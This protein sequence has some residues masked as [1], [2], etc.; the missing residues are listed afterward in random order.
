[1]N[2]HA[3]PLLAQSTRTYFE[4]ARLQSMNQWWHWMLLLVVCAAVVA[5]IAVLYVRDTREL[6]RG[7]RWLLLTLRVLAFVGLLVF[8]L[9]IEKRSEQ[10]L[11]KNSRLLV[12]VDTSQSMGLV[13]SDSETTEGDVN[14]IDQL[15]A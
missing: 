9:N 1:M 14:R 7:K 15:V 12:L 10:Q 11:V 6:P 13:D 3:L 2:L 5:W 4:V 8:F